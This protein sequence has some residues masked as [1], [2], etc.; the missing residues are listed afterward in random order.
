MWREKS[1]EQCASQAG[2]NLSEKAKL[3]RAHQPPLNSRC[4]T[5]LSFKISA[6]CS[7]PRRQVGR[8][9]APVTR[10]PEMDFTCTDLKQGSE[11]VLGCK[12]RMPV[13]PAQ[14]PAFID[15]TLKVFQDRASSD[16]FGP[17]TPRPHW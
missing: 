8:S 10:T 5:S 13:R 12:G 9:L 1:V 11:A 17:H 16:S 6:Q 15:Q 2:T 7:A 14:S 3:C 4:K